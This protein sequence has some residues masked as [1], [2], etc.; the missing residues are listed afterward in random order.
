MFFKG[1]PLQR[2]VLLPWDGHR[3]IGRVRLQNGLLNFDGE[4]SSNADTLKFEKRK[5]RNINI[6]V[7]KT[8]NF[9]NTLNCLAFVF[10]VEF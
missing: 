8:V 5:N 4:T 9:G 3:P 10:S 2:S 7:K 6:N 1:V